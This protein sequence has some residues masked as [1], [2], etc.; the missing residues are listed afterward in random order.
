MPCFLLVP[1][2]MLAL[3]VALCWRSCQSRCVKCRIG[4]FPGAALK[5]QSLFFILE[6]ALSGKKERKEREEGRKRRRGEGWKKDGGKEGSE[7]WRNGG[8]VRAEGQ[9]TA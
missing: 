3:S 7:G 6:T 9:G 4:G 2:G 5:C 8:R 1:V